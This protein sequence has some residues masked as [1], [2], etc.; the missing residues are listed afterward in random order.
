MTEPHEA[1]ARVIARCPF[2]VRR[3]V[4]WSDCDP[5]GVVYTGRFMDYVTDAVHLF[6]DEIAGGGG[7]HKWLERL[8]VDT[9]CKGMD[10]AFHHA[11]WPDDP[12]DMVCTVPAVREASYDIAFDARRGDLPIFSARFS[13]ICIARDARRKTPIPPAMLEALAPHRR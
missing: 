10:F 4:R 2:T 6:F 8:G 11:L 13:P 1:F 5:A 7:Y 12:F 9:P 3:V